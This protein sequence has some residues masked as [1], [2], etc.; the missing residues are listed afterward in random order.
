MRLALVR[1]D[2][3][4][5]G[6]SIIAIEL[7]DGNDKIVLQTDSDLIHDLPKELEDQ[8]KSLIAKIKEFYQSKE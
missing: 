2:Y 5:P 3:T 6:V 8:A 4:D 7:V 1:M